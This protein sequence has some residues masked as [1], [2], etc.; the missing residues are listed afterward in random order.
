M[1][2]A[3]ALACKTVWDGC[4]SRREGMMLIGAYALV[5]VGFLVA[6]NR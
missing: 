2:G 6:G 4:T 5:V 1:A 3:V